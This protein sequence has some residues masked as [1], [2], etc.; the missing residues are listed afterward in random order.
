MANNHILATVFASLKKT[1]DTKTAPN[2]G[3]SCLMKIVP[4]SGLN[5]IKFGDFKGK[6]IELFGSP[7]IIE[8]EGGKD[9]VSP[10]ILEYKSH[11]I[12]LYSDPDLGF[13]LWSLSITSD[14]VE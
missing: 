14:N 7:D 5:I 12:R 6:A 1:S 11:G 10:E 13:K 4:L 3:V 9:G 8:N 2:M